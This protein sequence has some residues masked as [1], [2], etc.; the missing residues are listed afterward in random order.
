M[1]NHEKEILDQEKEL[2]SITY[3][4][5]TKA[6]KTHSEIYFSTKINVPAIYEIMKKANSKDS[7]EKNQARTE[8]YDSLIDSYNSIKL[9]RIKQL[10]FHLPNN[11]SFLRFHKPERYGDNLTSIRDT[12]AYVNKHKEPVSGFEEGK[13][14][15]GY[16]FIYPLLEKKEHYGSVEIS[17]SMYE[18]IQ[19]MRDEAVANV[20]FIIK[21]N[22]VREKVFD[23]ELKNYIPSKISDDYLYEKSI[24]GEGDKL[25]ET[26]VNT[27][28]EVKKQIP[29]GT[30][31]NFSTPHEGK[32]YITT[33]IP[34]YNKYTK[35]YVASIIVNR[36]NLSLEY[37]V[38][39]DR[40]INILMVLFI[41]LLTYAYYRIK[42]SAWILKKKNS[43]LNDIQHI[44]K[45]GSCE[46]DAKTKKILWSDEVYNIFKTKPQSFE[47]SSDKFLSFVHPQDVGKVKSEF[48]KSIKEKKPY[49]IQHRIINPDKS[50]SYI[51]EAGYHVY[52]ENGEHIQTIGTIHDVTNII[53][54][55][56]K[57]KS[58]ENE[59][60]SIINHIPDILFRC[61]I[62]D[63]MTMLFVNNAIYKITG[64]KAEG[65][66]LNSV[67][68]YRSIIDPQDRKTITKEILQALKDGNDY[69]FEYRI[70]NSL[71]DTLWVRE[72]GKKTLTKDGSE[73]IE[74]LISDITSQKNAMDKLQ[75]FIDIQDS[76]VILTD[77]KKIL[78]ANKKF[79]DFFGYKSLEEFT[80]DYNCICNKF[81][82]DD[83]FFHLGKM[84][85]KEEQWVRSLLNLS[86]R[87]RIVSMLNS[88]NQAH[89]FSVSI[90]NYDPQ[91][92]IIN[93]SDIS[94]TMFEKLQLEMKAVRDQL[95]NA[96][97]RNYFESSIENII[98]NND[99]QNGKTGIIMFDIDHFKNIN[100]N[101]GHS[102]G[103][104]VL[105]SL[106][107]AVNRFIRKDDKLI[108]WGGEEFIILLYAKNIEDIK[109]EAE[110]LRVVIQNHKFEHAQ[111]LTCSFGVALHDSKELIE[112]TIKKADEKLYIAKKSGRNRV[113]C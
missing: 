65:F 69:S 33:F 13:I 61:K 29:T 10:H 17:V 96:Y 104:E 111:N 77:E 107:E 7:W 54:Y 72:T 74:G 34:I 47:P 62:D 93:F 64:Y 82:K 97:N 36:P 11:D 70:I 56:E 84:L 6:Y 79:F 50:I 90:N 78:F 24:S 88:K 32:V 113:E 81:V 4:T 2:L 89:A 103:D 21:K 18:I 40:F 55:E 49:L 91:S 85:P 38:E 44:A 39:K 9:F 102:V 76:I 12:V 80:K 16:R 23:D 20:E 25:L 19:H 3:N 106:V 35:K 14:Y 41:G 8:L 101:Y 68:S 60:E 75:K 27:H 15:N 71:G 26:I 5:I 86:G 108:R 109:K 30:A 73:I 45:L 99:K 92:Y 28:P 67:R 83:N 58:I 57:I 87:E 42:N 31:F 53:E 105:K 43:A 22:E 100:D 46:F 66:I 63:E 59:L 1:K 48:S 52:D 98:K 95:T 51:N 94:D 110:H 112:E 37:I